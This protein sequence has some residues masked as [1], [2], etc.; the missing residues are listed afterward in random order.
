MRVD[1]PQRRVGLHGDRPDVL[2]VREIGDA[3][4]RREQALDAGEEAQQ[5]TSVAPLSTPAAKAMLCDA[6]D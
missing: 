6:T 4:Q 3:V 1:H 2:R 5:A